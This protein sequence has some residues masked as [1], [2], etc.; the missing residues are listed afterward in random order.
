MV[1]QPVMASRHLM[2][3]PLSPALLPRIASILHTL[4]LHVAEMA[5]EAAAGGD[6]E[7]QWHALEAPPVAVTDASDP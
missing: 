7:A 3:D 2:C 6:A 5:V 4:S 1:S